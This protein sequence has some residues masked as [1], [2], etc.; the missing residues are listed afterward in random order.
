MKLDYEE[1]IK[2]Q[3]EEKDFFFKGHPQ[4]PLTHEQMH[5]FSKLDYFPVNKDLKFEVEL[6][7]FAQK[8]H[9]EM[10][11]STGD[12]QDYT[13]FGIVTFEVKG[14]KATLQMIKTLPIISCLFG[15]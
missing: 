3:R 14:E 7:E 13:D 8:K 9:I 10:Q 6:N 4:S 5:K 1:M 12:I 15:I 11:T 2:R